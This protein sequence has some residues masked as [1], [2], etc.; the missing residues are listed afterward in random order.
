MLSA[1]PT[2]DVAERVGKAAGAAVCA[3][4]L[5]FCAMTTPSPLPFSDATLSSVPSARAVSSIT[6]SASTKEDDVALRKL[7]QET[8]RVEKEAKADLKRARIEKSREAFFDYDAKVA[9][10][11]EARLEANEKAA[12]Q[13]FENDKEEVE[14]LAVMELKAERAALLATT[15]EEKAARQK[16][17]KALLAKEKA[18]EQKEKR[19]LK[20]EKLYLAEEQQ[21]QKILSR[22]LDAERAEEKEFDRV[23][24]KYEADAELAKEDEAELRLAKDLQKKK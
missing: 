23:E 6:T 17:V 12:E 8:R 21:E 14:T 16:E 19:A 15:K 9:L 2:N 7:E 3:L 4:T 13:E 11:T 24:K 18:I 1:T 5:S 20:A 22:K 10:E